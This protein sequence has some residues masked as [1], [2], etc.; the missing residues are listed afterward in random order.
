MQCGDLLLTAKFYPDTE[1]LKPFQPLRFF[2]ASFYIYLNSEEWLNFLKPRGFR[3]T[4][5]VELL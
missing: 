3:M 4:I 2:K 5:F 1:G